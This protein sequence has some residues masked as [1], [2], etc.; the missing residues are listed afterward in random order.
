MKRIGVAVGGSGVL[1]AV[2]S[3]VAVFVAV[4]VA[5]GVADGVWVLVGVALGVDV[6]VD[7]IVAVAV[8]VGGS[9]VVVGSVVAVATAVALLAV[10][11]DVADG[12]QADNKTPNR[13]TKTNRQKVVL[14]MAD[15]GFA[16]I[17]L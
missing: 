17:S 7:V 5:V 12:V 15:S 9:D 14:R 13:L 10:S 4:N 8:A 1:V 11:T 16:T 2:G 3:G 6:A